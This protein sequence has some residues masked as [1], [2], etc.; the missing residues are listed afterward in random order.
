MLLE[1]LGVLIMKIL[2][3]YESM[4]GN[5]KDVAIAIY[6]ALKFDYNVKVLNVVDALESDSRDADLYF[7]GSWVNRGTSGN[8]INQFAKTLKNKNIAIFGTAGF[9][10][11]EDYF[12][13]LTERFVA[14]ID[15]SNTFY[16]SYFCQGRMR[17]IVKERYIELLKDHP[18]D[19]SL[20]VK[21]EN[22]DRARQHP[23]IED[24]SL[25]QK[26]ALEVVQKVK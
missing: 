24:L 17:E 16:S 23:N 9:G 15:N 21:I 14:N 12:K 18:D 6:D 3:V 20:E 19:K 26:F 13:S 25:A 7:L 8:L 10:E 4:T 11:S 2:I 5:T 22:F 1:G